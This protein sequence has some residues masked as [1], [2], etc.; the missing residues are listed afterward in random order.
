MAKLI[1]KDFPVYV[2]DEVESLIGKDNDGI[3]RTNLGEK[4]ALKS[5]IQRAWN[6]TLKYNLSNRYK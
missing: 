1:Y 4:G 3:F 6:Y 5:F 2:V